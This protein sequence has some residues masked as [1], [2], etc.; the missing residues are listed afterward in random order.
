MT[1]FESSLKT[2]S[3]ARKPVFGFL[4]DIKNFEN[5]VPEG[6]VKN[7]VAV[8]GNCRFT[9]DGLG[10]V[11]VRLANVNP[12][13]TIIYESEGSRPFRFHLTI[14]LNEQDDQSTIMK[15]TFRAE[16]NMMMKMMV[17]KPL[18]DGLEMMASE[19]VDHLN[20]RQWVTQ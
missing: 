14:N 10:E 4:S 7:F 2:V 13:H 15:L 12:D 6:I 16:L 20:S 3:V 18:E 11:G 19:L 17:R 5:L 9:I 8:S 1:I